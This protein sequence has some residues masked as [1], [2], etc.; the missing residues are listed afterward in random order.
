[1]ARTGGKQWRRAARSRARHAPWA[2]VCALCLA[3]GCAT[4]RVPPAEVRATLDEA[5]AAAHGHAEVGDDAEA[6]DLLDA[7]L[8]IDP[9]HAGARGL[10]AALP[11]GIRGVTSHPWLGS[12]FARRPS[13]ERPPLARA[14]LFLPDRLLDLL[15]VASFDVH[16]GSGLY[17]DVHATR[18]LQVAGGFRSTD[19]LGWHDH[20]SLGS[21]GRS[22]SGVTV[23]AVGAH[24]LDARL[25][26]T[27]GVVRGSDAIAGLHR[28]DADLYQ[29]FR[30]YWAVG[31]SVTLLLL[32][33]DVDLHPVELADFALG[34]ATLDV[35]HDDLAATRSP[36]FTERDRALLARLADMARS[37]ETVSLY[38]ERRGARP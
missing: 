10:R 7:V 19:G 6:A 35:L 22:E 25:A 1:M 33:L 21:L 34:W 24:A 2:A 11:A 37:E 9:E 17:A 12:N 26:G 5:V 30:D 23:V 3:L 15:D 27:S 20:R 13:A 36:R 28:P 14:L 38:R 4:A 29:R 18:A 8:R 31:A 32:G 16:V